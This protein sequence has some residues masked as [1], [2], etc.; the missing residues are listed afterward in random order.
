MA[1]ALETLCGQAY[2]AKRYHLLG[3]Y[4]QR[5]WIILLA[6]AIVVTPVYIFATQILEMIGQPPHIAEK[7]G[8]MSVWM[9]PI[10]FS[11]AFQ[12]PL[13]RFLLSQLK[14]TIIAYVSAAVFVLHVLLSFLVVQQFQLGIGGATCVL[15]LTW[16][17]SPLGM[18]AYTFW[19]GCPLTWTGFS[20]EAFAGL[21]EFFKLS[22]ASGV[23]LCLENWYYRVL[24]LLTGNLQNPELAVDALSI[25]MNING[26]EMM[27]PFAFFAATGSA[28]SNESSMSSIL[29][30][31]VRVS[32]ELGAGRGK[33]ARFA[34]LVSVSTSIIIG[35]VFSIFILAFHD[36]YALA[37]TASLVISKAVDNLSILLAITILFNS[38]QPILS[39]ESVFNLKRRAFIYEWTS[40]IGPQGIWTG[41]IGG[42]IVQT[43]VLAFIT[44]RCD[45]EKEVGDPHLDSLLSKL[46]L[47]ARFLTNMMTIKFY[48]Q[49][50]V[51]SARVKK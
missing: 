4:L 36:K 21:W 37:F 48:L 42:T 41:M 18:L 30:Y 34:T 1:S 23:M 45:W 51:A 40:G 28:I 46:L 31:S 7:A 16:C 14:T 43:I 15:N 9:L 6:A 29:R 8:E 2:G 35:I 17:L 33:A 11:L 44:I 39:G 49:A 38:I 47:D 13:Q 19:G 26:W 50:Q 3:I 20:M 5:S 12:F 25:C 24:V 22:V 10:H 27:I 32:N